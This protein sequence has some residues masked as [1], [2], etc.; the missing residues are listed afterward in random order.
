MAKATLA[1]VVKTFQPRVL[2]ITL[3]TQEEL[4]ALRFMVGYDMTVPQV[5]H[6]DHGMKAELKEPLS[7]VFQAINRAI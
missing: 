2:T 3:E 4:D 5:L 1:P 7:G 6:L